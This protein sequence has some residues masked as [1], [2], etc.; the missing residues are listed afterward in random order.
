MSYNY[1]SEEQMLTFDQHIELYFVY[2][3]KFGKHLIETH[4]CAF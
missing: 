1:M 4:I 3:Q 2:G